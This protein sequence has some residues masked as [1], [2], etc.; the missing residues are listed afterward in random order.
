MRSCDGLFCLGGG[1]ATEQVVVVSGQ[2]SCK[3]REMKEQK[4]KQC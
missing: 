2:D 1:V 4:K 3:R